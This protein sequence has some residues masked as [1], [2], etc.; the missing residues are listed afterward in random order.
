MDTAVTAAEPA[1]DRPRLARL[2]AATFCH[3]VS[4]GMYIAAVPLFVHFELGGSRAIVGLAVGSFFPGA[5]L[6]RPIIGT[7]LDSWGRR[8]FV[9]LATGIATLTSLL[10]FF[11]DAVW[12]VIALG[13][14]RGFVG[15]AY[16]TGAATIATD[17]GPQK[18]RAEVIALFSLFLY[19]GFAVGPGLGEWLAENM[20]FSVVWF[21]AAGISALAFTL[22]LGLPETL[23]LSDEQETTSGQK[24]GL[25]RAGLAPGLV[26]LGAASGYTAI[27]G[28]A[29]L[30]AREIGLGT[31]G[32]L[33][34]TFS[35]TILGF[36]LLTRKLADRHGRLKI[37]LPGLVFNTLG[38]A[39][40]ALLH[41]PVAAYLAVATYG[42]GFALLFPALMAFTA[43]RVPESQRGSAMTTFTMFFDFGAVVGTYVVG[44]LA[45]NF[46][47]GAAFG[48]PALMCAVATAGI[49]AHVLFGLG[50]QAK[51][52]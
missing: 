48:L 32:G 8:P 47:F 43:D 35:L 50:R 17:L 1:L 31:S 10:F 15:A 34:A 18:R 12:I 36:R 38:L 30:Y 37:A 28:F 51:T 46:G 14:L 27:T 6:M 4:M 39:T 40:L 25:H 24:F 19:G 13:L 45:E 5:I 11:A 9:L 3:F 22:A 23:E 49:A 44:V 42:V 2:F 33:Y 20:G 7:G 29:P 21:T 52:R 26:L 41:A 16:Y